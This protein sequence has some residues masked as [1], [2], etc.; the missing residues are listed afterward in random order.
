MINVYY[1]DGVVSKVLWRIMKGS[2][3]VPEDFHKTTV[4]VWLISNDDKIAVESHITENGEIEIPLGQ[5]IP[6][7]NRYYDPHE[8]H[9]H[10]HDHHHDHYHG[11]ESGCFCDPDEEKPHCGVGHAHP[12]TKLPANV[13]SIKAV[14]FKDR[15]WCKM[16]VAEVRNAFAITN[17]MEEAT[18]FTGDE[19]TIHVKSGAATYG[20]DGL[21]AFELACMHGVTTFKSEVEWCKFRG[22]E[23]ILLWVEVNPCTGF[24][25]GWWADDGDIKDVGLDENGDMYVILTDG[26]PHKRKEDGWHRCA[27]YDRR[28]IVDSD[29]EGE[30][31]PVVLDDGCECT[32]LYENAG[33]E[34]SYTVSIAPEYKTPENET[35]TVTVPPA[36][37]AEVSY[38]KSGG[39]VFVRGV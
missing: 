31:C 13:Y 39:E 4:W 29:L 11:R 23:N 24:L 17:Y 27:R 20:Y 28:V 6:W 21:S 30:V 1:R 32:I 10:R 5:V 37:Y 16:S 19:L 3:G 38:L 34:R 9:C 8:H 15:S 33:D 36:G 18:P 2:S 14:W 12:C 35:L 26:N 7:H 25:E 22:V